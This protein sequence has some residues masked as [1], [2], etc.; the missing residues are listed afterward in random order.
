MDGTKN[1]A[2]ENQAAHSYETCSLLSSVDPRLKI[3]HSWR[4]V[5]GWEEKGREVGHTDGQ[6]RE[7]GGNKL[8]NKLSE[9]TDG[10]HQN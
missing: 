6:T 2:E 8:C 9:G 7:R 5:E 3:F 1:Q 10:Q 4:A